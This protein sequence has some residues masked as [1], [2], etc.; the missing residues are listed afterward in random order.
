MSKCQIRVPSGIRID[1]PQGSNLLPPL[2]LASLA[3]CRYTKA[4]Q[5]SQSAKPGSLRHLS[6]PLWLHIRSHSTPS[7][8]KEAVNSHH[9]E[10]T[11][12]QLTVPSMESAPTFL[13]PIQFVVHNHGYGHSSTSASPPSFALSPFQIHTH[14]PPGNDSLLQP[15]RA[16]LTRNEANWSLAANCSYVYALQLCKTR[17]MS[18][19][20]P[21]LSTTDNWS[22]WVFMQ[23]IAMPEHQLAAYDK[24]RNTTSDLSVYQTFYAFGANT[25]T[26]QKGK[27][28][29]PDS[30]CSRCVIQRVVKP[31]LM[32]LPHP[33]LA[34]PAAWSL[35]IGMGRRGGS[36]DDHG[37]HTQSFSTQSRWALSPNGAEIL[38]SALD[39]DRASSNTSSLSMSE[40]DQTGTHPPM[41]RHVKP[42]LVSYYFTPKG[43]A[44]A[45]LTGTKLEMTA[46]RPDGNLQQWRRRTN[47][48]ALTK[49]GEAGKLSA[50]WLVGLL[51][52]VEKP[53]FQVRER[54]SPAYAC[55]AIQAASH[56]NS[57]PAFSQS[58]H[59]SYQTT[60]AEAAKKRMFCCHS[61]CLTLNSSGKLDLHSV[62]QDKG[63]PD[64]TSRSPD[65]KLHRA[66]IEAD[67]PISP[68][69]GSTASHTVHCRKTV[70]FFH[71]IIPPR[72]LNH[73]INTRTRKL[74]TVFNF[75]TRPM[76]SL[77][78]PPFIEDLESLPS[79]EHVP[80]LPLKKGRELD[81]TSCFPP[82]PLRLCNLTTFDQ[83]QRDII[84]FSNRFVSGLQ[85]LARGPQQF[86]QTRNKDE[87]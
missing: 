80:R 17:A 82:L 52:T 9:R 25:V 12:R 42:A 73:L 51:R 57:T 53:S 26:P 36:T 32:Q 47:N 84:R 61:H 3:S 5:T 23:R 30:H 44:T 21:A 76:N 14:T 85:G 46:H 65:P 18:P 58:S 39:R 81:N 6:S 69:R 71:L 48:S 67:H 34:S 11:T 64:K 4:R 83:P 56:A 78:A 68:P 2:C 55:P 27:R 50:S 74:G 13:A 72:F 87:D 22:I 66:R 38:S 8:S 16:T 20:W 54:C 10:I 7:H 70:T 77:L 31:N 43:M 60:A 1:A 37:R 62:K 86:V 24:T 49:A 75:H 41:L 45:T 59:Q 29:P 15:L 33:I 79:A 63:D 28:K 19:W 35:E 40:V